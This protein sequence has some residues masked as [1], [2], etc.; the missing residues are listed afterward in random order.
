MNFR[1]LLGC[2]TIVYSNFSLLLAMVKIAKRL[3]WGLATTAIFKKVAT[4]NI[5]FALRDGNGTHQNAFMSCNVDV[6]TF[7]KTAVPFDNLTNTL[8]TRFI[9]SGLGKV[10]K[11]RTEIKWRPHG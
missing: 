8:I 7:T 11:T 1:H 6:A 3:L 9:S 10:C 2:D 4:F 5:D